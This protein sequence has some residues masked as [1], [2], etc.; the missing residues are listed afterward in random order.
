[1]DSREFDNYTGWK[2]PPIIIVK[3]NYERTPEYW[4]QHAD[5]LMK[6]VNK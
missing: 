3:E 5:R 4:K 2:R 1:M 6:V